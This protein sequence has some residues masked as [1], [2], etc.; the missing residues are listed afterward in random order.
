MPVVGSLDEN[1]VS[2]QLLLAAGFGSE[3]ESGNRRMVLV[4]PRLAPSISDAG[5]WCR[6]T[7]RRHCERQLRCQSLRRRWICCVS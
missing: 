1:L 3:A 7:W 5:L 6:P 4:R 2:L